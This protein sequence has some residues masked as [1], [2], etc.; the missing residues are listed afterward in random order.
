MGS[1]ETT[2]GSIGVKTWVNK[3]EDLIEKVG[4]KVV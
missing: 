1:A 4:A 3:G 2:Y